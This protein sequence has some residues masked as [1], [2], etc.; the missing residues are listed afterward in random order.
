MINEEVLLLFRKKIAKRA[1]GDQARSCEGRTV[2]SLHPPLRGASANLT[3]QPWL[4]K[5][6]HGIRLLRLWP[7]LF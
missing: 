1:G 4:Y 7:T 3:A 6:S 5:Y 2:P